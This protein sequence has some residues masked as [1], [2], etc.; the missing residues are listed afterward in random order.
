MLGGNA[1]LRDAP[2]AASLG[3]NPCYSSITMAAAQQRMFIIPVLA[4]TAGSAVHLGCREVVFHNQGEVV[5]ETAVIASEEGTCF[6]K[7]RCLFPS[8]DVHLTIISRPLLTVTPLPA[9]CH[10]GP[11]QPLPLK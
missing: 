7:T 4:D 5:L 3:A 2:V 8:F 11:L 10:S 6:F 1:A 9:S